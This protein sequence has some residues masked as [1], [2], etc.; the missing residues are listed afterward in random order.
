M[1]IGKNRTERLEE[2]Q[3]E[4]EKAIAHV[5]PRK[6][7]AWLPVQV[8]NGQWV[9]LESVWKFAYDFSTLTFLPKFWYYTD[10]DEA[11]KKS[12]ERNVECRPWYWQDARKQLIN[13]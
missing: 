1:K 3:K 4:Y 9:W 11:I 8:E 7:F 2:Y 5:V 13:K 6:V 10:K 12:I